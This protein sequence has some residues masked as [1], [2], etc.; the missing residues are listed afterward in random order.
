MR[1]AAGSMLRSRAQWRRRLHPSNGDM[2]ATY[3]PGGSSSSDS[4]GSGSSS[5]S[6]G[7]GAC[8]GGSGGSAQ[9]SGHAAA[10]G[11]EQLCR[12]RSTPQDSFHEL[13]GGSDGV[14]LLAVPAPRAAG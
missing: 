5:S 3:G 13:E 12:V 10:G 14:T 4:S 2:L 6:S 7:S 11:G 9:S 1:P 8:F